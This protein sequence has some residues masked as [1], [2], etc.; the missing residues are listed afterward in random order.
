MDPYGSDNEAG[1]FVEMLGD[2]FLWAIALC[3]I[4]KPY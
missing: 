2:L 3:G 4:Y 1:M